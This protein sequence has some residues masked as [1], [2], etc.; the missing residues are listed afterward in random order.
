[1]NMEHFYFDA[2]STTQ[3]SDAALDTYLETSRTVFA[4]PSS[5]HASG[6]QAKELLEA[7]RTDIMQILG[8][9]EHQVVF[10]GGASE[11]NALVLNNLLWK[12]TPGRVVISPLEHPSVTGYRTLFKEKHFEWKTFTAPRGVI[13]VKKL[14]AA[15]NEETSLVAVSAVHN[16]LGTV[17]PIEEIYR[18]VKA[19]SPSIHVHLDATQ[20]PGKM[21]WD[22][23]CLPFD[24]LS[25]SAHKIHGPRGVGLLA[26]RKNSRIRP[27]S[28]GGGQEMGFRGGT[29]NLPAIAAFRTALEDTI[30]NQE[31]YLGHLDSLRSVLVDRLSSC[32][33][34][35][36]LSPDGTSSVANIISISTRFPSEVFIRML[37]DKGFDIS[38]SSACS[39]NTKNKVQMDAGITGFTPA[40]LS[41]SVRISFDRFTTHNAIEQLALAIGEIVCSHGR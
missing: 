28:S 38:A 4:N 23:Q 10:T 5:N 24:S 36:V 41:G 26:M 17:Q 30:M 20:A 29:E 31:K 35:D 7:C 27:L 34:L 14:S 40:Q 11:S 25:L 32:S 12:R 9:R 18:T 19:F 21:I 6:R 16:V 15:L 13:D 2:A 33:S 3:V 22:P 8:L 37:G 39:N 1:M